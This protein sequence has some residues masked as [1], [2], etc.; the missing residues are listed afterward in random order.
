MAEGVLPMCWECATAAAAVVG[1]HGWKLF[2]GGECYLS[3][4]RCMG[5]R[6][7]GQASRQELLQLGSF[8]MLLFLCRATRP[9]RAS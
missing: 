9:Q 6:V 7:A 4:L 8:C 3:C 2:D 1:R 5:V